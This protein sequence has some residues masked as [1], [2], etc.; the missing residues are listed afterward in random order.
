[1]LASGKDRVLGNAEEF[2]CP[3]SPGETATPGLLHP[4]HVGDLNPPGLALGLKAR[5][6][7]QVLRRPCV[8]AV[9]HWWEL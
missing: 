2:C 3:L 1:M 9:R 5:R 4:L 6:G 7:R 8:S